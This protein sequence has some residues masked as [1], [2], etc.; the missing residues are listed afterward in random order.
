MALEGAQR[1]V[2]ADRHGTVHRR[3]AQRRDP[4]QGHEGRRGLVPAFHVRD[5]IRAAGDD[6]GVRALTVENPC[7]FGHVDGRTIAKPR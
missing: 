2:S 5:Q 7:G 4:A 3:A 1:L 6:H